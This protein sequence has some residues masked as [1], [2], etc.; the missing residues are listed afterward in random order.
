MS[1]E[2]PPNETPHTTV[3][4]DI[5][6]TTLTP[7]R[8]LFSVA[9]SNGTPLI[10]ENLTITRDGDPI[11]PEEVTDSLG[12][13][14]HVVDAEPGDIS[15]HYEADIDTGGKKTP[16]AVHPSSDIVYRRPSRYC[17]SDRFGPIVA[18]TFGD[19]TG[20]EL[21]QAVSDWV[22]GYL[23]Y[24][25]GTSGSED[26]AIDTYLAGQGVCRDYAH[27][28]T[29]M[30]RAAGVAARVASVYAPGLYPMDFHLVTEAAVDGTWYTLDSTRLA[31]RESLIRIATGRDAADTAFLTVLSGNVNFGPVGVTAYHHG[32]LLV[33]DHRH[34]VSL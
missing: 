13:R 21:L 29:A 12:T 28:T 5:G 32:T 18:H 25:P 31:P 14:F 27:L 2:T 30:L 33:D 22:N 7:A 10:S 6:L 1:S 3:T 23:R 15:L 11:T 26:S 9:V 8:L 20:L 34:P 4:A 16:A 24:I 17:E 19:T